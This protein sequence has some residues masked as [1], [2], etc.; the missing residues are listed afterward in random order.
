M[1]DTSAWKVFE[2]TTDEGLETTLA[3]AIN[4]KI[5]SFTTIL[6]TIGRE[7]FGTEEIKTRSQ[8]IPSTNRREAQIRNI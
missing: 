2:D 8:G 6:Y 5:E 4:R 1:N 3:Y 7:T